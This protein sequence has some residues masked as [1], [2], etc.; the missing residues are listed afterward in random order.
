MPTRR[1]QE[2]LGVQRGVE[3]SRIG[4]TR[5]VWTRRS[6]TFYVQKEEMK[7]GPDGREPC[8]RLKNLTLM[9]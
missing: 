4:K 5:P 2:V 8:A 1:P 6:L 3:E 9:L 7:M